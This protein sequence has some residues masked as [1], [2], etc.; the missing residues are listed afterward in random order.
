[1]RWSFV[2]ILVFL[3]AEAKFLTATPALAAHLR[4]EKE[5][6]FDPL[7]LGPTSGR[8]D[9]SITAKGSLPGR[10]LDQACSQDLVPVREQ[11]YTSA[12]ECS[13][14]TYDQLITESHSQAEDGLSTCK[15]S[16]ATDLATAGFRLVWDYMDITYA[17]YVAFRQTTQLWA[18]V[19]ANARGKWKANEDLMALDICYGS[20]KLSIAGVIGTSSWEIVANIAAEMLVLCRII[21]FGSFR[22]V[23]YANWAIMVITLAIAVQILGTVKPQQ[24]ITTP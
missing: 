4:I 7:T 17:S 15:R 23:V 18:N 20:L 11:A 19:T 5:H 22:V 1:M 14:R 21:V 10:V 3:L 13:T 16:L 6:P 12:S 9:R 2:C 8:E 24:L